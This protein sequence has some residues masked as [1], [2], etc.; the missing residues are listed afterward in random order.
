MT[1]AY[2]LMRDILKDRVRADKLRERFWKHVNVTAEEGACWE[3]TA[4][5]Q[6]SG[7]GQFAVGKGLML[8][9]HRA[10]CELNGVDVPVG[11]A[12]FQTCRNKLCVNPLHLWIGSRKDFY[13]NRKCSTRALNADLVLEIRASSEPSYKLASRLGVT[14]STVFNAREGVT[15]KHVGI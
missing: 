13:K 10:L 3:W 4:S 5:C 2:Q 7:Y 15:W 11:M 8:L 1:P 6:S 9:A 14:T 12:V